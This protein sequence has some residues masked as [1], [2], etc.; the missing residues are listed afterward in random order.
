MKKQLLILFSLLLIAVM[1]ASAF[2]IIMHGGSQ[3]RK[4]KTIILTNQKLVCRGKGFEPCPLDLLVKSNEKKI[5][6]EDVVGLVQEQWDAGK[7]SGELVFDDVLP[8]TWDTDNDD[9]ITI[10]T[11]ED[12]VIF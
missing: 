12:E 9:E 5:N 8:V 11:K 2:V 3:D 7:K 1:N 6:L 10:T 4:Y